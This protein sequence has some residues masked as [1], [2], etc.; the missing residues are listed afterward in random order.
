MSG[1]STQF[2]SFALFW[3][4]SLAAPAHAQGYPSCPITIIEPFP[5]GGPTDAVARIVAEG[6]RAS[7]GQPVIIENVFGA[8]GTIGVARL[9]RAAPE[10]ASGSRS[11]TS[12]AAPSTTSATIC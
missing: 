7:L 10:S 2:A 6:M 9:A 12:S 3:V 11:R 8:G 5:P 1:H 4:M